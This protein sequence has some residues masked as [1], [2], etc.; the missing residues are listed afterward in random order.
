MESTVIAVLLYLWGS[1][2]VENK[3]ELAV[4][5]AVVSSFCRMQQP[6]RLCFTQGRLDECGLGDADSGMQWVHMAPALWWNTAE[7]IS[8]K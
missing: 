6:H 1:S 4:M 7:G 8:T 5:C 2:L 3:I